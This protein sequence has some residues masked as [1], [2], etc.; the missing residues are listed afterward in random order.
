MGNTPLICTG[1]F[2][3]FGV[4]GL[5]PLAFG[6]SGPRPHT[7]SVCPASCLVLVD[8][9]C[10]HSELP[11]SEPTCG[12]RRRVCAPRQRP[13]CC[14]AECHGDRSQRTGSGN[15]KW[16][17]LSPAGL[18]G[19]L[20]ALAAQTREAAAAS[21]ALGSQDLAEPPRRCGGPSLAA[22]CGPSCSRTRRSLQGAREWAGAVGPGPTPVGWPGPRRLDVLCPCCH[23]AS[24][25]SP[26]ET[27]RV[28][29][30]VS[31]AGGAEGGTGTWVPIGVGPRMAVRRRG[32]G[33]RMAPP[34]PRPVLSPQ[35]AGPAPPCGS[36]G[37]RPGFVL[38]A[39][40]G[41]R[42]AVELGVTWR[43]VFIR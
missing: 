34:R 27:V 18:R 43:V 1:A 4:A 15:T 28:S 38:P 10:P 31:S 23:A 13:L 42:Q 17:R 21:V 40:A 22:C 24:G 14:G 25:T 19:A 20:G 2:F 7:R 33:V 39:G 35:V 12:L 8:K 6:G 16:K 36:R 9:I 26:G 37:W 3:D 30:A 32:K 41:G 11:S 29:G 5:G